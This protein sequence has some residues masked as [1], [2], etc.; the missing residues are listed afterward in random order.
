MGVLR[1]RDE[2][3]RP[4][5]RSVG[6]LWTLQRGESA[7]RCV[8]IRADDRLQLRVL[9]DGDVLR[10][11]RCESHQSAFALGERWRTRMMERGW[12]RVTPPGWTRAHPR[13][14]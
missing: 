7:A 9:L 4:V 10:C 13:L 12:V 5:E 6:T 1:T 2:S 8:L 3:N 14:T 11:E